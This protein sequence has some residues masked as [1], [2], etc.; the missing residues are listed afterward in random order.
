MKK[1]TAR[2]VKKAEGDMKMVRAGAKERPPEL[3]GICFHCQ[4]AAEKYLKGYLIELAEPFPKTHDLVKLLDLVLPHDPSLRGLRRGL[5][6]LKV[7]A[8]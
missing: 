6:F 4:Q 7:F 5:R 8:V 3:D 1:E 2:W